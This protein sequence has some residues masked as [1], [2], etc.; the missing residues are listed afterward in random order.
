LP[1]TLAVTFLATL[2]TTLAATLAATLIS[3]TT[4]N[5]S[6][7][8]CHTA[9]FFANAMLQRR[10]IFKIVTAVR[11]FVTPQNTLFLLK[12]ASVF[13]YVLWIFTE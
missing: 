4:Y 3:N 13:L 11:Q 12:S 9:I 7:R 5:N 8:Q 1:A 10:G 2:P 6:I